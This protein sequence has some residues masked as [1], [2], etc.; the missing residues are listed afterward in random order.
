MRKSLFTTLSLKIFLVFLSIVSFFPKNVLAQIEIINSTLEAQIKGKTGLG[1]K[2]PVQVT[3][4]LVEGFLTVLGIIAI[5][6]IIYGGFKWMT[7]RGNE[8]TVGE[9]KSLLGA[10]FI[11]LA[12]IL[13]SYGIALYIFSLIESSTGQGAV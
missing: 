3:A 6:L 4:S 12:I 13:S 9:A 1:D 2:D 5:V 10:S 7:A 8:E 11:G